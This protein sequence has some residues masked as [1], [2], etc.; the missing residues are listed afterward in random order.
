MDRKRPR[1]EYEEAAYAE[2]LDRVRQELA[3]VRREKASLHRALSAE[4][5]R[6]RAVNKDLTPRAPRSLFGS[7]NYATIVTLWWPPV[8]SGAPATELSV[9]AIDVDTGFRYLDLARVAPD[10]IG[11][12]IKSAK[13]A[14]GASAFSLSGHTRCAEELSL[15]LTPRSSLSQ[16]VRSSFGSHRSLQGSR[17][18]TSRARASAS[19]S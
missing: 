9:S 3:Q 1:E 2:E 4:N 10:A 8:S 6:L 11:S 7:S 17:H 13:L 15:S 12:I 19:G 16:V 14:A 5:A 18:S